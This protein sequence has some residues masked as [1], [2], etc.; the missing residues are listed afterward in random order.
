ML[1]E[2]DHKNTARPVWKSGHL[3]IKVNSMKS[4]ILAAAILLSLAGPIAVLAEVAHI[5]IESTAQQAVAE[6]LSEAEA[7]VTELTEQQSDTETLSTDAVITAVA[8]EPQVVS[9]TPAEA[10]AP[11]TP[12]EEVVAGSRAPDTATLKKPCP[13]QGTGMKRMGMGMG[14]GQDGK[15]PG[16]GKPGCRHDRGQQGKHEQVVR[17]LDMIEARIAKMEAMLE[18]LMQR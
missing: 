7:P 17:R 10:A 8:V 11:E 14:M 6:T 9:D 12:L 2:N 18:S 1:N 5:G 4:T 15:G 16:C 13:M 3:N